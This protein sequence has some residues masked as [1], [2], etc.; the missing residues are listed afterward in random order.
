[1]ADPF[2]EQGIFKFIFI[3]E[4]VLNFHSGDKDYYEEWQEELIEQNGWV[5]CINMP[6][7][8]QYDFRRAKLDR[9]IDLMEQPDWRIYKPF[10]LFRIAEAFER[11]K[12]E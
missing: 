12:L 7:Q 3:A 1:V 4:N 5:V 6:E 10:H 9:Y 8:T 11:K 2:M